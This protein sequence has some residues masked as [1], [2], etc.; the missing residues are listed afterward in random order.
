M[1]RLCQLQAKKR[2]NEN[3]SSG[4]IY[5]RLTEAAVPLLIGDILQQ[6]YNMTDTI[7]IGRFLG[8]QAFAAAGISSTVMNLFTFIIAGFCTGISIVFANA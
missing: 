2:K 8:S 4:N 6:L 3:M 5:R 1:M 7:I